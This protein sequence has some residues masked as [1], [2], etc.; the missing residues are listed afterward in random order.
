VAALIGRERTFGFFALIVVAFAAWPITAPAA[1]A[2]TGI[3]TGTAKTD[4]GLPLPN[5]VVLAASPSG[6]ASAITDP[7]GRFTL[8][9]L[10]PDTY[11]LSAQAGG[12]E[13]FTER[14]TVGP[15]QM[16]RIA[17]Q[18]EKV[19][20]TVA[21]V[22]ASSAAFMLGDP[23]DSYVVSGA[24]AGAL[25]PTTSSAG[26]ANYTEG[27]VQGAIANV[28]GVD[29]DEFANAILRGAKV[30]DAVFDYDSIPIPQG[31]IAEPGGNVDGAQLPTTGVASTTTTLAGYTNEGDNSLAGVIN[32]IAA[33]GTYPSRTSLELADGA[34]ARLQ[35][36]D[37]EFLGASP[38]LRL[39]YAFAA[40][41]G[42]QY[43]TYGNGQTFYPSEAGTYGIAL[44][45]RSQFSVESNVHYRVDPNDD[46]SLLAIGGQ[47]KYDQY[48]SPFPGETVGVLDGTDMNGNV[49]PYPGG[50]NQAAPVTFAS[51]VKGSYDALKAEWLHTGTKLL[52]RVQLYS[53]EFGSSAGG[54][55]WDENGWPDGAISLFETSAQR[56]T[57][58][59]YDGDGIFGRNRLRFGGEYRV[60]TSLLSQVVPTANEFITSRPTLQSYLT[61]LSDTYSASNRLDLL[62]TARLIGAHIKPGDGFAYDVGAIDPHFAASYRLGRSFALR[63]TFDHSTV[64]P[65]PL[66]AD[67]TDSTNVQADGSPAP[68]VP[69]QPEKG[70]EFTYSF[71]SSGR[72]QI[73]ATYYQEFEHNLIDVLPFNFRSALAAGLNPNGVGVPTNVGD[74]R[75]NGF[76]LSAKN[77]G[78]AFDANLVRAFSSSASQ[79]AYND[80][81]APA[82]AAGHLFPVSYEPDLTA[83][84]SYE[85]QTDHRRLRITPSLS[86]ETGYP[87]GNGK[88]VY[89]FNPVTDKPELVPN[90]NYVNPGY[91]YYFLQNPAIPYNAQTN[92]YIGDL[93]TSE[94]RDPNTLRSMPQLLVNLHVEGDI[95]PRVTL[96]VDVANM[97][98]EFAPTA[99]QGNPYLIG[100]PGYAGGNPLYAATYEAAGGY[101]NLYTL[102]NGVPTN[103][104]QTAVVPWT[105][106]RGGYVPQSYPLGRTVELRLRYKM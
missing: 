3:I 28:P 23:S 81:N 49:V 75:A 66:E 52:S 45:N 56:Q 19:L 22:H 102:G 31:L 53:S 80:L 57:G 5:L 93:G 77:G 26:L 38:D 92:P 90:D 95:S 61:Y 60:N 30:G 55:F 21:T 79:F 2:T 11:V 17:F 14:V 40:R 59:N 76:E 70:N 41:S 37:Y 71:E 65:A 94:G 50:A 97:L 101:S 4:S 91:N 64:A 13:P 54:P 73:R 99:Y 18:L 32:Q 98:G 74:L 62:G 78:F 89:V 105:Y 51:G 42:S 68:F 104:G 35:Q 9:G 69:L 46:I 72:T 106:G 86:Y 88:N 44:Q 8:L 83:V 48:G 67:R 58:V 43:L 100:P 24:A 20:R 29:L 36:A 47:A 33:V 34:D 6:R 15:G 87:Y 103:N 96:M 63:T 10:A 84:L 85:F 27:T 82:V 7:N 25:S 12:Y 39:R 16:Q 1:E